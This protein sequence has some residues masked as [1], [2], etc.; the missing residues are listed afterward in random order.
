MKLLTRASRRNTTHRPGRSLRKGFTLIELLVV[1]AIIAI[2]AAMLLP[3]LARARAKGKQV[4]CRNNLRQVGLAYV[5][6]VSDYK[7]YPGSGGFFSGGGAYSYIWMTRTLAYMGNNHNAFSCP[8]APQNSWWDTNLNTTL[9][10]PNEKGVNDPFIVTQNARFSYGDNDWGLSL[11]HQPT[12]GTGGDVF[13]G[14]FAGPVTESMVARPVDFILVADVRAQ[15]NTSEISFDANLDPTD[16]SAGH[17]QWPS[18]RHSGYINFL[19]ADGHSETGKRPDAVNP[20]STPWRRRW[21]NDD[22]AHDG[23]DGDSVGSWTVDPV[24]AAA[25]DQS[26]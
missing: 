16:T 26:F 20:S 15:P 17:S 12:L 10:G 6:Y 23:T 13:G 14:V 2:L 9:G 5:M 11:S 22:K 7:Q 4:A 18:N 24:A 3:A 25:V 1:I 19:F 8:A 21:N